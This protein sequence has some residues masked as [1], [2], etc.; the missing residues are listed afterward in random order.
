MFYGLCDVMMYC[1]FEFESQSFLFISP[2]ESRPEMEEQVLGQIFG[3]H[4]N[5]DGE[6]DSKK[7]SICL[8]LLSIAF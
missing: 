2:A 8:T 1:T 5:R 6:C 7:A 3:D 4:A